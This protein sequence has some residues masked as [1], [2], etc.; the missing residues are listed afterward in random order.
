MKK[1]LILTVI[2]LPACAKAAEPSQAQFANPPIEARVGAD[3]VWLNG[4][5]DLA[6]ITR[7]LEEM[8]AKGMS[9]A[10]IWDVGLIHLNPDMTVTAGPAFLG[11]ESLA[12]IHYAIN[13]AARLD[14]RLGLVSSSSWNEGGSWVEPKDALKA[15]YVSETTFTGPAKIARQL[16]FPPNRARKGDDGLPLYHQEIAVLAFPAAG[17]KAIP[18]AASV[19]NLSGKLN[20]AGELQWNVPPGE[21]TVLRFVCASTGQELVIPSPNSRGLMVDHMD[22]GAETRNYDYIFGQLLKRGQPLEALKSLKYFQE[23]SIEIS[24]PQKTGGGRGLDAKLRRGIPNAPRIRSD[25]LSARPG[26]QAV[27]QRADCRPIFPRLPRDRQR[28]VD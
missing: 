26:R 21:W 16:P 18:D 14:L 25:A 20:V 24:P 15:L 3:W 7:E 19:I 28:P 17:Q 8:K 1:L 10:E 9:G 2:L 6:Q 23:D 22:A 11:P 5:V 13:E 27:R 4:N 12:A